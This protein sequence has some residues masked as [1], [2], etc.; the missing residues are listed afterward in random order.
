MRGDRLELFVGRGEELHSIY[1][2]LSSKVVGVYGAK[3]VGKSSFLARFGN[4]LEADEIKVIYVKAA[5]S[6]E[7]HIVLTM[8]KELLLAVS[9]SRIQIATE[10][11][12]ER[13]LERIE[14]S[15]TYSK[16]RQVGASYILKAEMGEGTSKHVECHSMDSA[17]DLC[18]EIV[19]NTETPFVIVVDDLERMNVAYNSEEDYYLFLNRFSK[20]VDEAL[21]TDS[22]KVVITL[23]SDYVDKVLATS[24]GLP[25]AASSFG[26]L[27]HVPRLSLEELAN[28]IQKRL[29][30]TAW[31]GGLGAFI[32]R[33]AFW[34]LYMASHG[35]PRRA[36]QLLRTAME[37]IEV[38]G[39]EKCISIEVMMESV[40]K[41]SIEIDPTDIRIV[42][43]LDAEGPHSSSDE[44]LQE[45][46]GL[47][48]DPLRE[49]LIAL[50]SSMG[51]TYEKMEHSKDLYGV[52]SLSL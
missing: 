7:E 38:R 23:H 26:E 37:L 18:R 11:D 34:V 44:V 5:G 15:F 25:E 36:L 47:T 32:D 17:L 35:I 31:P 2:A 4:D 41:R 9:R 3:G 27:I 50:R 28:A 30:S 1:N 13:E 6:G 42:Q 52:P 49:R 21:S 10:I 24:E 12:V 40:A 8:L 29:E 45:A 51:L 14:H 39:L 43:F 19:M 22:V 46:A 20:T 33:E 48:R 16:D